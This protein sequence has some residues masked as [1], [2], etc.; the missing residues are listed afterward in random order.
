MLTL[1]SKWFVILSGN[2]TY[3]GVN[4]SLECFL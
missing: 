1:S 3:K 4:I 2:C